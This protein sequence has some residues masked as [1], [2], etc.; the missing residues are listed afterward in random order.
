[1]S[2]PNA[3]RGKPQ[4]FNRARSNLNITSIVNRKVNE[5]MR[6]KVLKSRTSPPVFS[7]QPWNNTIVRDKLKI[8]GTEHFYKIETLAR[9]LRKQ[10]GAY[11]QVGNA[12]TGCGIEFQIVSIMVWNINDT[13][14]GF[15]R[16]LPIDFLSGGDQSH[17]LQN[18]SSNAV[19]NQY[20]SCGYVFP[21]SHQ[22]H[23]HYLP[24][25]ALESVGD[26]LGTLV[27]LDVNTQSD[28]E[29]HVTVRW[30]CSMGANIKL[31][32]VTICGS[33]SV[34][35]VPESLLDTIK[36]LQRL[37]IEKEAAE[38][39]HDALSLDSEPGVSGEHPKEDEEREKD[40]DEDQEEKKS[41]FE[42]VSR[43]RSER[44]RTV[45]RLLKGFLFINLLG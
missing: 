33:N 2:I 5:E 9:A 21:S 4:R 3:R 41:E 15:L 6:G 17:E 19:K 43:R 36:V 42:V 25:S 29:M 14:G 45:S 22:Q 24:Q 12:Y 11:T 38:L 37:R 7:L 32:Y 44:T 35:Q 34:Q 39:F 20:A 28:V 27:L 40:P 30:R 13:S 23:V 10:V 18:I 1:M 8:S 26:T 31:D 16:V